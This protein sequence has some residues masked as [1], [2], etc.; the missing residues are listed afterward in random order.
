VAPGIYPGNPEADS[1]GSRLNV[2]A[3]LVNRFS[4]SAIGHDR[5]GIVSA[6]TEILFRFGCNIE[7]SAMTILWGQFA[8]ILVVTPPDGFSLE[9]LRKEFETTSQRL[10]LQ[11]NLSPIDEAEKPS[12]VEPTQPFLVSVYGADHPGIVSQTTAFLAERNLNITDLSTRV[13][14]AK[15]PVYIMLL[16]IEAPKSLTEQQLKEELFTLSQE[17]KVDISLR[18]LEMEMI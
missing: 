13:I 12:V 8:M 5:P 4:L 7:D 2:E 11:V 14:Q 1:L 3:L 16:E 10:H 15:G 6:V 17:L 9:Q 18:R